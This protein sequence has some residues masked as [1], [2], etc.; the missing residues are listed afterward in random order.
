MAIPQRN[1][2]G[3]Q[4]VRTLSGQV[5]QT[6]LPYKAYLRIGCLEMEKA[7]RGVER[8]SALSRV[9]TIDARFQDIEA[10]KAALLERLSESQ[11]S[12][13]DSTAPGANAP[14]KPT[15]GQRA[16]RFKFRY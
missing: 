16:G 8:D 15:S 3:L 7:R 14:P 6:F 13:T 9:S 11:A 1:T 5:D 4:D 10:E 2:R 12:H